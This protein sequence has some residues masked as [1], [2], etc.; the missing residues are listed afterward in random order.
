MNTLSISR[1][2]ARLLLAAWNSAD[3]SRIQSALD[4]AEGVHPARL[5]YAE[6]ERVELLHEIAAGI[7]QWMNCQKSGEDL[8][9]S[10]ELLRHLSQGS[11]LSSPTY[12]KEALPLE[13][14]VYARH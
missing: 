1:H 11:G 2:C 7:R 14:P 13:M 12:I 5:G 4:L 6:Q 8:N 3:V 9:V 10:L